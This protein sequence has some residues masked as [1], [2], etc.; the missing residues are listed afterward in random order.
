MCGACSTR[1]EEWDPERGGDEYAYVAEAVRCPGCETL[2][3]A[4]DSVPTDANRRGVRFVLVPNPG[5]ED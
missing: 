5:D 4:R 2:E 1:L 3:D